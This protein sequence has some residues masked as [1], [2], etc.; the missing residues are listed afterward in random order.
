MVLLCLFINFM[1]K[2]QLSTGLNTTNL[3]FTMKQYLLPPPHI[4]Y[5]FFIGDDNAVYNLTLGFPCR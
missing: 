5:Q 3:S 1:Y 4:D 2:C